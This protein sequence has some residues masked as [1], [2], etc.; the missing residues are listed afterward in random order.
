MNKVNWKRTLFHFLMGLFLFFLLPATSKKFLQFFLFFPITFGLYIITKIKNRELLIFEE[1]AELFCKS[2]DEDKTGEGAL[3]FL[4]GIFFTLS[5]FPEGAS[6]VSILILS[7]SDT[8]ARIVGVSLGKRKI[9]KQKTLEGSLTFFVTSFIILNV[10]YHNL[11]FSG[12]VAGL[13]TLT[14]ILTQDLIDDNFS[15][16]LISGFLLS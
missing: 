14:E 4:L 6:A 3:L 7:I 9:L 10:F 11:I 12:I 8:S 16:P 15:I 13:T 1:I 2:K 5:F